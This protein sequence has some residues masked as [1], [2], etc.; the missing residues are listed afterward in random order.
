MALQTSGPISVEN[1][2]AEAGV[3]SGTTATLAQLATGA[4]F[5]INQ[6]S[7]SKPDGT[8]PHSLSEWYGYDHSATPPNA[9]YWKGDGVNDYLRDAALPTLF[10]A[11]S[12]QDMTFCGWFRIDETV[13]A[14]QWLMS[15]SKSVPDGSNQIFIQYDNA[16]YAISL[17]YRHAGAFHQKKASLYSSATG[18]TSGAWTSTNR[19][20]V[21][22]NGFVFLTWTYDA[23]N[24]NAATGIRI[25]WNGAEMTTT[26]TV[27]S[28]SSP[29]PWDAASMAIGDL[30]SSSPYN[31]N[32]FNGGIDEVKVYN[33]VLSASEITTLYNGGTPAS[34]T[35]LGVTSGILHE[36]R[37]EN[38]S[39]DEHTAISLSNTGTFTAY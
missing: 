34:A 29:A 26:T 31:A 25:Y 28:V 1:V 17:R 39:N 20:N 35:A 21:N 33:R 37:M 6:N 4:I 24:R 38:N 13:N 14:T 8:A 18:I 19:G 32:V 36:F 23:S 27:T 11:N 2:L 3:A 12:I 5:T 7:T 15:F 10:S 9:Y 30:I 16:A 22:S